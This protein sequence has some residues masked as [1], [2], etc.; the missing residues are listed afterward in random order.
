MAFFA[1]APSAHAGMTAYG[2][3]DIYRLRL[4]EIS[5][6]V[7]LLLAS[8][9][10]VKFLWNH[11]FQNSPRVPRLRFT[12]AA[13]LTILF[14]L[15]TLLVLTMI[16]GIREVL[17]PEAWRHQGTSYRLNAPGHEPV[18]KR[19][20]EHLRTALLDYSRSHGGQFPPHDF[21]P[22]IN[23]KLWESPDELGTRYLYTGGLTTNDTETFLAVE[24]PNFGDRRLVLRVSGI[25]EFL[26]QAEV[27]ARFRNE[28]TGPR[29]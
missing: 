10:M 28:R 9:F 20:L 1:W 3:R 18:R 13:C 12:Q 15:S 23:A 27:D 17:T 11:A 21:G 2:L 16:S 14:G 5:F 7:V 22:E 8:V 25:I 19:S 26:T 6:F 24:P 29:P 4:E